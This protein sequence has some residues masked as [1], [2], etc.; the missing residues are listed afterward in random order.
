MNSVRKIRLFTILG[1]IAILSL[2]IVWL[3]NT[4]MLVK[5][6]LIKESFE[7]LEESLDREVEL[8]I[9]RTPKETQII[10]GQRMILYLILLISVKVCRS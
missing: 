4:Y 10:G 2:Q 3:F 5:N 6:N 1:L 7:A 8:R 9:E